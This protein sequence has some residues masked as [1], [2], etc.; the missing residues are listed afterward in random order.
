MWKEYNWA[1][2]IWESLPYIPNATW[3]GAPLNIFRKAE[4]YVSSI[5]VVK[6]GLSSYAMD[7]MW[8]S[9]KPRDHVSF[10]GSGCKAIF[11]SLDQSSFTVW[12]V[13]RRQSWSPLV[14]MLYTGT[15]L[16][17][18][19]KLS[20]KLSGTR[21]GQE[22]SKDGLPAA[23]ELL[24]KQSGPSPSITI[25]T[26]ILFVFSLRFIIFHSTTRSLHISWKANNVNVNN[27]GSIV[28]S[29]ENVQ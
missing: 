2:G 28:P 17:R 7:R 15:S 16:R 19:T 18:W 9:I 27:L 24:R 13:R 12:W 4:S 22:F 8:H 11:N 20:S 25:A 21:W 29:V 14:I 1:Y 10:L 3:S 23:L 26:N 5:R 6:K